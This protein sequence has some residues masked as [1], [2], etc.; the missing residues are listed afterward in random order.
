MINGMRIAVILIFTMFFNICGF[1]GTTD[2]Q[3][4]KYGEKVSYSSGNELK[5][6]DF[7]IKFTGKREEKISNDQRSSLKMIFYDFEII[8]GEAK[9]KVFWSSGTGDIGPSFF[10]L[11][12][13]KYVLELAQS[14]IIKGPLGEG[15][16]VIWK[17]ADFNNFRH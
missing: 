4:Q 10:E 15:N 11:N 1:N 2:N 7:S 5:F 16:L 8:N 3:V 17:N 9:Q 14:D 12:G 13:E 6:P